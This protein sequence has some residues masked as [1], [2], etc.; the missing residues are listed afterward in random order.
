MWRILTAFTLAALVA[1]QTK[2]DLPNQTAG[3]LPGSRVTGTV[4]SATALAAN[5]AN[6][7]AGQAAAGVDASGA[8]EGC[9]TPA[10]GGGTGDVTGPASSVANQIPV[11]SNTTGKVI[12]D[13]AAACSI[14]LA[15]GLKCGSPGTPTRLTFTHGAAP[16]APSGTGEYTMFVDS[17][18]GLLGLIA[19]GGTAKRFPFRAA[20]VTASRAARFNA[21]GELE[22]VAGTTTDCVTVGGGS[23]TCGGGGGTTKWY[24]PFAVK[25]GGS[26]GSTYYLVS[27]SSAAGFACSALSSGQDDTGRV[28]GINFTNG[29]DCS[30]TLQTMI[31]TSWN[32]T[33][34][35]TV[36]LLRYIVTASG[37]NINWRVRISCPALP[38]A[39]LEGFTTAPLSYGTTLTTAVA[40]G[41][42]NTSVTAIGSNMTLPTGCAAGSMAIFNIQRLETGGADTFAN[43][44]V[45]I[46]AF[47]NF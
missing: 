23:T 25:A 21:S 28:E 3:N 31:P 9:F 17:T 26:G 18:G 41:S 32:G 13:N 5:G 43:D 24:E 33:S 8:A 42:A 45:G 47:F 36:S 14:T 4:P 7:A 27:T 38:G 19:N 37:G 2:L 10:A 22:H 40:A 16:S 39:W 30:V 1:A 6:C 11:F 34:P 29:Q 15:D 46:G 44:V 35:I 20:T 12:A